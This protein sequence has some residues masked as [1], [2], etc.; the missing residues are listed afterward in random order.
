M[1]LLLQEYAKSGPLPPVYEFLPV[2]KACISFMTM[3]TELKFIV[4]VNKS[5]A[6]LP[7][8]HTEQNGEVNCEHN[9][10]LFIPAFRA[11]HLKFY[12]FKD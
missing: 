5:C 10:K 2:Y 11:I 9:G 7:L 12:L 6:V 4:S 1:I 8:K 3:P